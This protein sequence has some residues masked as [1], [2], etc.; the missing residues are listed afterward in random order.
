[1]LTPHPKEFERLC[2]V[3]VNEILSSPVGYAKRFAEEYDV[4]LLLKGASTVVAGKTERI[5]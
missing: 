1:M 3:P 5:S 2:G 4:I